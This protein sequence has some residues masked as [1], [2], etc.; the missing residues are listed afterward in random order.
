[1]GERL[2]ERRG[3]WRSSV[4]WHAPACAWVRSC[5]P[6]MHAVHCIRV[7]ANSTSTPAASS[8]HACAR[9]CKLTHAPH[10][11][12]S[13]DA[14][15][16][17]RWHA[18]GGPAAGQRARGRGRCVP[19]QVGRADARGGA[20]DDLPALRAGAGVQ[21]AVGFYLPSKVHSSISSTSSSCATDPTHNATYQ[22]PPSP[23]IKPP[24]PGR[25]PCTCTSGQ[26]CAWPSSPE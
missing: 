8:L 22:T 14:V 13:P 5:M 18:G 12:L 11:H 23:L 10:A 9:P 2:A 1:M 6:G 24:N 25:R 16:A 15:A 4:A 26:P 17:R 7:D 3:V 21:G 19:A 20:G